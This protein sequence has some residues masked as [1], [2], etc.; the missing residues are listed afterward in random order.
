[1]VFESGVPVLGIC[2]GQM[3]MVEHLGGEVES[4]DHR[5]FGRAYV[6]VIANSAIQVNLFLWLKLLLR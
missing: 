6:D 3:A 5:E 4:S 2:Y 1:M